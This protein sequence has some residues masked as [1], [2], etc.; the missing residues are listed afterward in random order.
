MLAAIAVAAST[1]VGSEIGLAQTDSLRHD[2]WSRIG[3]F[4]GLNINMHTGSFDE[5]TG[6][7]NCCPEFTSGSG[8]GPAVGVLYEHLIGDRFAAALRVGWQGQGATLESNERLPV[9]VDGVTQDAEI[10]HVLEADLSS[11]TIDPMFVVAFGEVVRLQIGPHFGFV[12][13]AGF[14]QREELVKPEDYGTFE[15]G[16]RVRNDTSGLIPNASSLDAGMSFG[17]SFEI[18]LNRE[19]TVIAAP[20]I[21]FTLDLNNVTT[22]FNDDRSWRTNALRIGL[23]LKYALT[24]APA[25]IVAPPAVSHSTPIATPTSVSI[26]ALGVGAD[27]D[28]RGDVT[29]HIEE[30]ISTNMRP[31][32]NYV[33]F[34]EASAEIPS[35]YE[36]ADPSAFDRYR[37]HGL[38]A[39]AT[40]HHLLNIVAQR[41]RET[42]RARLTLV[43]A[44][45]GREPGGA[46]LSRARALAVR[47]YLSSVWQIDTSRMR[48]EARDLP[49]EPSDT[50]TGDGR[51]ENRRVE[52]LV[53]EPDILAPVVTSD[54]LRTV[55]PAIIRFRPRVEPATGVR[56]WRIG[57]TQRGMAVASFGAA[58]APPPVVNWETNADQLLIPRAGDSLQYRLEVQDAGGREVVAKAAMPVNLITLRRKREERIGDRVI[59]RYSLIL[60]DF[61]RS[62][63]DETNFKIGTE[64]RGRIAPNATVTI[65]GHS[66]RIGDEL[67]NQ[68]LSQERARSVARVLGVPAERASGVG[69]KRL[70]FDNDLP[71]GRFYSRTVTIVVETP[72]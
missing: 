41:M 29:M 14:A 19:K 53:D 5:L 18:P 44:H 33:F 60:F 64:V 7:P 32:L 24:R 69:E 61:D 51:A 12:G 68:R 65:T 16:R 35:R 37:L 45:D 4:T 1:L 71:E 21:F 31:L 28:E 13:A 59:D 8:T 62:D 40:Y 58:G 17:A 38:D 27:G 47:N 57:A 20:E 39:I 56:E 9:I 50:A 30:F 48:I 42:P 72:A 46:A 55:T 63:L 6:V 3:V 70:L 49:L 52:L 2:Q 25:P 15:N 34:D 36:R 54:T 67:H 26:R 66:D 11:V 10:R 23:A 43:G 22:D